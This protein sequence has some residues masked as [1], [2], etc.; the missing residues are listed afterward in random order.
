MFFMPRV[1]RMVLPSW[2]K[3]ITK[4]GL[5]SLQMFVLASPASPALS[6]EGPW[7]VLNAC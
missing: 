3:S 5:F 2:Y 4:A 6:T 7:W 1:Y